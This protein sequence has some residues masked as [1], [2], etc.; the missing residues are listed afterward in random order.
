MFKLMNN[1]T[2]QHFIGNRPVM[3]EL[4]E[5][6]GAHVWCVAGGSL[7]FCIRFQRLHNPRASYYIKKVI[8]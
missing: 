4:L 8:L 2:D 3:Y 6:Y 1:E 7:H 5:V